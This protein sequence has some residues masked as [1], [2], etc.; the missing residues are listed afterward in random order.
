MGGDG[1]AMGVATQVLQHI[2]GTAKGAFQVHHPG[3]K[4]TALVLGWVEDSVVRSDS[5]GFGARGNQNGNA[6]PVLSERPA[7][8]EHTSPSILFCRLLCSRFV[9]FLYLTP[10]AQAVPAFWSD[11]EIS[12]SRVSSSRSGF[13]SHPLR[14][15]S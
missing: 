2:G 13:E 9:P 10:A 14:H 3:S 11:L 5:R 4:I 12:K 6:R 7:P 1:H 8:S 15:N